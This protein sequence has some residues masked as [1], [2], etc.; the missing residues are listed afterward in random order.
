M[1][2][3][4]P[5]STLFPYTTL[6]RSVGGA[7]AAQL[8]L[9]IGARLL[10]GFALAGLDL[11]EPD[12]VIAELRLHRPLDLA[13]MHAVERIRKRRDKAAAFGPPEIPAVFR[14]ARVLGILLREV[15]KV[16]ARLRLGDRKS[17]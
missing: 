3:R 6:F 16:L 11:I 13:H 7:V 10:E 14:R 17:T 9:E 5:R 15:A 4:P 2:R 8:R 12:D 1:I